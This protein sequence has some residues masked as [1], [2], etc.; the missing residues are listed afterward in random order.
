MVQTLPFFAVAVVMS[1]VTVLVQG[2][3]VAE[4]AAL[5]FSERLGNALV[6]W[7]AYVWS[8]AWPAGLAFFYPYRAP[9]GPWPAL[10][11]ALALVAAT[12]GALRVARTHPYVLVGWLWYVGTLVP[13]IG[14][15]QAG[16]QA[17]A[18][19]FTY[20]PLI[21]LFAIV[22]WG[23]V[24]LAARWRLPP[25]A[26]R[27]AAGVAVAA[28]AALSMRQAA[29]WRASEPLF[30]HALAVTRDNYVAHNLLGYVRFGQRRLDEAGAHFAA[31]VAARPTMHEAH[32]NLGLVL[33]NQGRFAEAIPHYRTSIAL[34]PDWAT[35]H[36]NLAIALTRTGAPDEARAEAARA[37]ALA[38][39]QGDGALA[40]QITQLFGVR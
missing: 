28:C 6:S 9:V 34:R 23:A 36:F 38:R 16:D 26:Q 30:E 14:L 20:V 37:L 39:A 3:A 5:P 31:A 18:D 17:M 1:V 4:S 35:A 21:G 2:R 29:T 19:R 12:G 25:V 7:V 40:A 11:A 27:A 13:V 33:A 24:D 10:G 8:A 22:A 15:V 32:N